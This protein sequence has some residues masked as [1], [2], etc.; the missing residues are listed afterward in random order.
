[1]TFVIRKPALDQASECRT[2]HLRLLHVVEY[3]IGLEGHT[4]AV[5]G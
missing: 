4:L 2:L 5:N 1:M 3:G